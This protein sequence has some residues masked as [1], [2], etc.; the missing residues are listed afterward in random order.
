MRGLLSGGALGFIACGGEQDQAPA[1][2]PEYTR[3]PS[4][5]YAVDRGRKEAPDLRFVEVA[6]ELGI[7]FVHQTGAR[8]DKWMPE[9]MGSGCALFDHDGDGDLDLL[10][11]NCRGGH[12]AAAAY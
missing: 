12:G 6:A 10:L 2:A 3:A 11:V 5:D 8:G 4:A 9:T 1:P 7:H